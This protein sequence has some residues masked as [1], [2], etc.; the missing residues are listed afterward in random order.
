MAVG[1]QMTTQLSSK[2]KYEHGATDIQLLSC[3][4]QEKKKK[5]ST[6]FGNGCTVILGYFLKWL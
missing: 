4:E 5:R 6:V 1:E 2:H 3:L